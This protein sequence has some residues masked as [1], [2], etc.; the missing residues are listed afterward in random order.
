VQTINYIWGAIEWSIVNPVTQRFVLRGSYH[1]QFSFGYSQSY[2]FVSNKGYLNYTATANRPLWEGYQYDFGLLAHNSENYKFSNPAAIGNSWVIGP[3]N[4]TQLRLQN[5][6]FDSHYEFLPL[7]NVLLYDNAL[8]DSY[9]G[10]GGLFLLH[11]GSEYLSFYEQSINDAPCRGPWNGYFGLGGGGWAS[12]NKLISADGGDNSQWVTGNPNQHGEYHGLDYMLM[13]NLYE[14]YKKKTNTNYGYYVNYDDNLDLQ[15]YTTSNIEYFTARS[16]RYPSPSTQ[17]D[18]GVIKVSNNFTVSASSTVDFRAGKE[19]NFLPGFT[20]IAGATLDAYIDNSTENG[21]W[22]MTFCNHANGNRMAVEEFFVPQKD[23]TILNQIP[24]VEIYASSGQIIDLD[25]IL[26][27]SSQI[28]NNPNPFSEVTNFN[29]T[30]GESCPVKVVIYDIYGKELMVL[31]DEL[32]QEA[33]NYKIEFNASSLA[34][35]VYF[36]S[37]QLKNKFLTKRMIIVK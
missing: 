26:N 6:S 30:I 25:S 17:V 14:L 23:R 36:Y 29:Y 33:G 27:N 16:L 5:V 7:L 28:S 10:P 24:S 8:Y 37:L 13:Y 32:Q 20:A 35:G 15:N 12:Y 9:F 22:E 18:N 11:A 31:L 19:I 34:E 4:T 21:K 2:Q 1:P 3:L